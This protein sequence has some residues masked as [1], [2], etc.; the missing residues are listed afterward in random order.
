MRNLPIT[1]TKLTGLTAGVALA[2][3]V[4]MLLLGLLS[5]GSARPQPTVVEALGSTSSI[6][7]GPGGRTA[8]T[9]WTLRTDP[10]DRGIALGWQRGGFG[11]GAVSLPNVVD[12]TRYAGPAAQ[13]NYE[14]SV[15][16]YRTALTAPTAG[17]YALTFQSANFT[18]DVWIDGHALGS[19]R[20]SYLPFELRDRLAAGRHTLV[21]RVDWR[22]PG[23]Q[24]QLGYHRTWFNW[25]GLDGEVDVRAIGSSELANPTIQTTLAPAAGSAGGAAGSTTV[26]IGVEVRNDGASGRAIVPEGSLSRGGQTIAL[27]FPELR[28]GHGQAARAST[29]VTVP[30]PALWSPASPSLYQL[31][32][33]VGHESSYSARVGL[34]QLTWHGGRVYLNGQRLLLHG[35]SIQEDAL[36]HGD[37]LTPGDENAIVSELRAI[38]ANAVRT[39][40]PLYPSLLE[41]LDAAGILVWQGIGPVEGAGNWY[42]STPTLLAAAEGQAR[43]AAIAD[44]LHPSIFAWNLVDEVAENG[45]DSAEVSYVQTLTRWL[46]ARDPARMVAVDVWGD[47]PPT[48]PGALYRE[49][50]AIAETDYSGWYDSPQHSPAAVS[51]EISRRL[52]AMRRTFAGRVLAVSEFG[53][54]SNGLN[55]GGSPGSYS[56]QAA[57]L[58]R[59]IR[60]YVADPQLSGM[61]VYLLRDY[62]LVPTFEGGSIH[63]VLPGLRLIE[64]INQKG[65]FSYGGQP[66]QAVGTIARLYKALPQG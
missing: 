7:E 65:L 51:A 60:A 28:L 17:V 15:A 58:A 6:A 62:P 29:S 33:A 25:G 1:N 4:A 24:S 49:A 44:E 8:L 42:S 43:T 56:F 34:R 13:S 31:T 16:W 10:A 61:F 39:Q 19:H 64:G 46:H 20:G 41:R 26:K 53:A 3:L 52:E 37:A 30:E 22:D 27:S 18:A 5:P 9:R 23:A 63:G 11:G 45:R 48:H 57:L 2:A 50:D 12:P 66:K 35:A 36:G 38:G 54:E 14:G 32:L 21:V 47:H 55:P 40:H 59:H